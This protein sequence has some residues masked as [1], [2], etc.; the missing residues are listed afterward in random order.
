[1]TSIIYIGMDVHTT[2]YTLCCYTVDSDDAFAVVNVKPDYHEIL[3]YMERVRSTRGGNCDFICGYEAGCLGYSLYHQLAKHGVACIILAP[4]TMPQQKGKSI[5]T[6]KRDAKNI[7]KCLAFNLYSPVYV[8]TAEDDAI[9][10]YI[11]MRDDVKADLK[12]TKQ[13]IISFCT[14]HGFHYEGKSRWTQAYF[15]WLDSLVFEN[16]LYKETLQEYL[17][18]Y[19]TLDEKIAVYD[20]RIEELAHQKRY[21]ENVRK[22]CCFK[23]VSTHTALP[24]LVE[25]GDFHRFRTAQHFSA[26]LGLVPG[27]SSSGEKVIHTNITKAGNSHLR[28]LLVES[29]NSYSRGVVGKKS[30]VMK[31][32][33]GGNSPEIIAYADKANERLHRKF[34]KI[35]IRSKKNVAKTAI[36]ESYM[37]RLGDDDQSHL[38]ACTSI[39]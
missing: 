34:Y 29:A 24:L 38:P 20:A 11:R 25:V 4:S 2:N 28:T 36:A 10:E 13:Q 31:D 35:A 23:G 9:K 15:K 21:E 33:Q 3:K 32:K 5:K 8:P 18:L 17:A 19:Y 16:A 37:F 27:E 30:K 22:L 26:Y 12:R 6:D 39:L 1:M 14:R 7:A